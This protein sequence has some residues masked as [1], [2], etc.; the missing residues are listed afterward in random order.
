VKVRLERVALVAGM[1]V[2]S[3]SLWTAAP[4]LGLWVGSRVAPSS[5]ISMLALLAVVATIGFVCWLL[6]RALAWMGRTY[7]GLTGHTATVRRHTPWL[8][9]MSGER[10]HGQPGGDAHLTPLE[11]ILVGVVLLAYL[12]FELW[13]FFLSSSPIDQ[14]SGR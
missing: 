6:V 12:V 13:F 4:L 7:D 8:R 10:E 14:R 5:G 11:Y 3:I 9:S 1:A 2:S